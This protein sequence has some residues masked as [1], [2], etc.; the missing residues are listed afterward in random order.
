MINSDKQAILIVTTSISKNVIRSYHKLRKA[1]DKIADVFLLYHAKKN[2]TQ[3]AVEGIEIE[4]FTDEI[5]S[6]LSYKP[7]RQQIV[8]GSNHFPVLQ[9]FLNYP[10]YKFYWS[11]ED[12]VVFSGNWN[13]FFENISG[14]SASDFITSHIRRYSDIPDWRWWGTLIGPE[15]KLAREELLCSFNPIYRISNVALKHIDISLKSG[16]KGHHEVLLPTLLNKAGFKIA[17]LATKDNLFTPSLSYCTLTTM[18]WKPV[19]FLPRLKKNKLYHPVK[20][21]VTF[22]QVLEYIKRNLKNQTEYFK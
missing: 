11:V 13:F 8:P 5:L 17:D 12:D 16:Y 7:I 3:L 9:F 1:T 4:T 2:G 21:K 15:G 10:N 6:N 14:D 18:R 22:K 20:A 19:F